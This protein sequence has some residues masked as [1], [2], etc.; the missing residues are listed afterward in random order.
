MEA[1]RGLC[2]IEAKW[3]E[4]WKVGVAIGQPRFN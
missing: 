4:L 3:D 1:G 2:F